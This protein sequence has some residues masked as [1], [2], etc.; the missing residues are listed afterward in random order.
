MPHGHQSLR[1][2]VSSTSDDLKDYR[3]VARQVI[4]DMGWQAEMMEHF[5]A[6]PQTTSKARQGICLTKFQKIER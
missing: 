5:E 1:V 2:F 6:M 3:G 4:M